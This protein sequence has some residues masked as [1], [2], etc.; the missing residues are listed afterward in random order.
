MGRIKILTQISPIYVHSL[1]MYHPDLD[2]TPYCNAIGIEM[3][4]FIFLL[5]IWM[6][7]KMYHFEAPAHPIFRRDPPPPE[8]LLL[9]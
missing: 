8:I 9:Y 5:G 2:M 4:V 6:G 3:G 7:G 1:S